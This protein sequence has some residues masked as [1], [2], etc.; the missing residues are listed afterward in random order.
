M[1]IASLISWARICPGTR[2]QDAPPTSAI[3]HARAHHGAITSPQV[4]AGKMLHQRARTKRKGLGARDGA[5]NTPAAHAAGAS[6]EP[7]AAKRRGEHLHAE[8]QPSKQAK[9][10]G[11]DGDAVATAPA[12]PAPA[13]PRKPPTP[14][15]S[16]HAPTTAPPRK[17]PTPRVPFHTLAPSRA[18]PAEARSPRRGEHWHA[19]ARSAR[20][21]EHLHAEARSPRRPPAAKPKAVRESLL[22]P[23]LRLSTSRDGVRRRTDHPTGRSARDAS[24]RGPA[25]VGILERAAL[26]LAARDDLIER[27]GR[28]L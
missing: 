12:L 11:G 28:A 5:A 15:I 13:P 18:L 6:A 9:R 8:A 25:P 1:L 17:P 23:P 24:R 16:V 26:L 10:V 14:R 21:G 22:P 27:N 4:R 20:R 3:Q 7:A 2:R 19:E